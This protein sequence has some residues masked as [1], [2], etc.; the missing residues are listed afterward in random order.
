MANIDAGALWAQANRP[1]FYVD[2]SGL[3]AAIHKAQL[4]S[5]RT[6]AQAVNTALLEVAYEAKNTMP[7]VTAETIDMEL[8]M[9]VTAVIGKRGKP[10]SLKRAKNRIYSGDSMGTEQQDVELAKLIILARANL[11]GLNRKLG[12]G[13]VS[14]YNVS[15]NNR[16]A[17]TKDDLRGGAM[18]SLINQMIRSRRK[19]G[20]FL[21]AGWTPAIRAL[22][23]VTSNRWR[24]GRSPPV[25]GSGQY[26][27]ADL[28]YATPAQ[29]GSLTV[30]GV[31]ANL[32]GA[33]GKN[34]AS[35]AQALQRYGLWPTQAAVDK[36]AKAQAEYY[37]MKSGDEELRKEWN[38]SAGGRS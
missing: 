8:G 33:Q 30:A 2:T 4:W 24:K 27:G 36:E 12:T 13:S 6:L 21:M 7:Y 31:I 1:S 19:S 23:Q 5:T 22:L 3:D 34:A 16:Y 26:Y 35:F 11:A 25:E 32:V 28:G 15:T 9:T 14:N 17:L 37:L 38:A 10:L 18:D 29:E 20:N